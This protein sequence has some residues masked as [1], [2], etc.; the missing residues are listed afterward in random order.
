MRDLVSSKRPL[1][2]F[3]KSK[4][5]KFLE[6]IQEEDLNNKLSNSTIIKRIKSG[7]PAP[8]KNNDDDDDNGNDN[9]GG[10]NNDPPSSFPTPF[11]PSNN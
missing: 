10:D 3:I 9:N 11:S 1:S 7:I 5:E 2:D 4:R 8:I 6:K